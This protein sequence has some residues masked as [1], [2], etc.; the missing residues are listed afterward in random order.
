[1]SKHISSQGEKVWRIGEWMTVFGA[2]VG[3]FWWAARRWRPTV[4]RQPRSAV[5]APPPPTYFP[6]SEDADGGA[7]FERARRRRHVD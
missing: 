2:M 7:A 4:R 3:A 1:M 5:D 6:N